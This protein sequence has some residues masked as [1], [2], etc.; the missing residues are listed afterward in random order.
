MTQGSHA[1]GL[2]ALAVRAGGGVGRA[3]VGGKHG[4][5]LR[6][7]DAG[8]DFNPVLEEGLVLRGSIGPVEHHEADLNLLNGQVL[9][10]AEVA[11]LDP[12]VAAPVHFLKGQLVVDRVEERAKGG[13]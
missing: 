2:V 3:H 6:A 12:S 7:L 9:D 10:V 11:V 4:V 8:G 5:G 13:G 1:V